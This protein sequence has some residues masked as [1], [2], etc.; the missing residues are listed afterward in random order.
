MSLKIVGKSIPRV[1]AQE[2]VNGTALY[3]DDLHFPQHKLLHLKVLRAGVPHAKIN[4]IDIIKAE[5][6]P[7]VYTVIT[8]RSKGIDPDLLYGTCI[9]DQPPLAV[10]KVRH[11]GEV[12]AAVIAE[13]ERIAK[14]ALD[15]I[16][17]EYE[18]L[19]FVI[20]P[21]KASSLNAPLIHERNMEYKHAPTFVP[22]PKTNIFFKY[23]LKKGHYNAVFLEA[24]VIVEDD[25]EYPL[26]N[27]AAIFESIILKSPI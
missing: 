1:D 14:A 2:K 9:F 15:E 3:V 7:G 24:D 23:H 27:H 21:I 20:D 8:G 6:I 10:D 4:T 12:I 17:V 25:F 26:V 19:P 13:K 5:S 11:A 18:E 16:E 22:V